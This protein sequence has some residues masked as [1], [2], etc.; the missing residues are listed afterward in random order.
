MKTKAWIEKV[1]QGVF[2]AAAGT[3]ILAVA[4]I[5]FFLF[6]NGF[7]AMKE[8]GIIQF[9]TGEVWKPQNDI[10]GIFQ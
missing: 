6:A 9:L 5:C 2:F 1:M 4:L 8:I 7:P 3:S 10:Y